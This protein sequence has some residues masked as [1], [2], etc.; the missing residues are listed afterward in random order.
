[1]KK[2]GLIIVCLLCALAASALN[3]ASPYKG[4]GRN[5]IYTT[6][7]AQMHS[8]GSAGSTMAQAPVASMH[9]T[10]RGITSTAAT[11]SVSVPQVACIRTTAS[12][13]SGGITTYDQGPRRG[14]VRKVVL[15]WVCEHCEFEEN[16]DG[17][18]ECIYCHAIAEDGCHCTPDCHCNVPI[19][20]GKE[21]WLF[22]TALA[23]VYALYKARAR[24]EQLI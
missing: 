6:S 1:M 13:I 2:I 20:D 4:A 8:I 23:G 18:M 17:D 3:Y 19:G 11:A 14:P 7:S 24:K 5:G 22:V 9:S 15:P 10:S 21:V 16:A 12:A